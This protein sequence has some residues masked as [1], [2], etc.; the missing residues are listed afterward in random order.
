[1]EGLAPGGTLEAPTEPGRRQL[2][3][4]AG[5]RLL[6][7]GQHPALAGTDPGAGLLRTAG[8]GEFRLPAERAVAHVGDQDRDVQPY[9]SGR[10]GA[11][12][13]VGADRGV[14]RQRAPG[15]LGGQQLQVVPARQL[16]QRHAHRGDLAL[17]PGPGQAVAGQHP[18]VRVLGL[19]G[20]AVDVGV[21]PLIGLA[22]VRLGVLL[23]PGR[24]LVPVDQHRVGRGVDPGREPRQ[25]LVIGVRA[26]PRR[27]AVVVPVHTADQVL[28]ADEAVGEQRAA[29]QASPVEHRDLVVVADHHQ[30]DA[31]HQRVCGRTVRESAPGRD[32]HR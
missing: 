19:L 25:H 28:A 11:D 22:V 3:E 18:D 24:D 6:L 26:D 9:G 13:D 32:L 2:V 14:V 10:P 23:L 7:L 15:Q 17:V 30:V 5:A 27:D 8:Q 4:V 1:M 12:H 31:R 16:G 29:M 21:Q 20:A